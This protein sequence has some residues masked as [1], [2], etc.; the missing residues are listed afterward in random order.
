MAGLQGV[1][2]L[3]LIDKSKLGRE[4]FEMTGRPRTFAW[5]WGLNGP[6]PQILFDD[7]RVGGALQILASRK[8]DV[9]DTRLLT[10]L[11]RDYPAPV[12][13]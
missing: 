2:P 1:L 8:L 5:V 13:A 9:D 4:C 3:A 10:Q 7:P 12:A 11:A 6:E